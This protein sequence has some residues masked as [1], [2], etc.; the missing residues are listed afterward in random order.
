MASAVQIG[1]SD[2]HLANAN[3]YNGPWK[4]ADGSLYVGVAQGT[5]NRTP[6]IYKS[7]DGGSSWTAK[8]TANERTADATI[9]CFDVFLRG[10]TLHYLYGND[11]ALRYATFNTATDTWS[12]NESVGAT[13]SYNSTIRSMV[14]DDG[15]PVMA[16]TASNNV[17][18]A[19]KASGSWTTGTLVDQP[20]NFSGASVLFPGIVARGAPDSNNSNRLHIFFSAIST[21][22]SSTSNGIYHRA[23]QQASTTTFEASSVRANATYVSNTFETAANTALAAHQCAAAA[24]FDSGG[25]TY[26]AVPH[27]IYGIGSSSANSNKRFRTITFTSAATPTFTNVTMVPEAYHNG[28]TTDNTINNE[29]V[30]FADRLGSTDY[31]WWVDGSSK[32]VF[33]DKN[34]GSG[35]GTDSTVQ[36]GTMVR[37]AGRIF[38]GMNVGYLYEE[39]SGAY[40]STQL[41]QSPPMRSVVRQAAVQRAATR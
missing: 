32:D 18:I 15:Q 24:S 7:T 40:F 5:T 12:L 13:S 35:F 36:T 28:Y 37:L 31:V 10:T 16:Y 39:S 9:V 11:T 8:D 3:S 1:T 6:R 2:S 38:D 14:R 23:L 34:T 27:G 30:G 33:T 17:Y 4:T 20:S 26:C 25:S 21:N 29:I 19:T 22:T 41:V